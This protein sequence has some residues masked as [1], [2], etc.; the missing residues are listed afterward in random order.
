MFVCNYCGR[1]LKKEYSKCPACGSN[2]FK[3]IQNIGEFVIKTP[4]KDGYKV[5]LVNYKEHKKVEQTKI[6]FLA[7]VI[8][9]IA[10]SVTLFIGLSIASLIPLLVIALLVILF[11]LK[12]ISLDAKK[13]TKKVEQLSKKGILI[14]NLKYETKTIATDE[15]N[16]EFVYQIQVM[17][18]I[19]KGK[20]L[21]FKSEPKYLTAL[22]RDNGT[23]DLLVDPNDY[24]NYFVDFEIY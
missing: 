10:L 6:I 1:H 9:I 11:V 17:Y 5:N 8:L 2:S 7:F 24:S 16:G 18:E 3:K 12:K 22:G 4:P 13:A 19:E 20:T 23:V 21:C 14:K 15:A